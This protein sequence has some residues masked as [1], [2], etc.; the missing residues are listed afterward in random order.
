MELKKLFA[1]WR[2]SLSTVNGPLVLWML[3]ESPTIALSPSKAISP[4]WTFTDPMV[5]VWNP[6]TLIVVSGAPFC[7]YRKPS[8]TEMLRNGRDASR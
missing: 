5:G 7:W 3:S 6:V 8:D 1:G 4:S 2:A